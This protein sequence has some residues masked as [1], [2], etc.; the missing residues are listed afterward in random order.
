MLFNKRKII[1]LNT[2]DNNNKIKLI[3]K[4]GLVFIFLCAYLIENV[5]SGVSGAGRLNANSDIITEDL[6]NQKGKIIN[7]FNLP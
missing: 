5:V 1:N 4:N 6:S 7:F 3:Q 2:R